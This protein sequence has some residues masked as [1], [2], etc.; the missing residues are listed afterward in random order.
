MSIKDKM[1]MNKFINDLVGESE[2]QE[3]D[4]SFDYPYIKQF[5]KGT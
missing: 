4:E 3:L 5:K 1:R 2:D